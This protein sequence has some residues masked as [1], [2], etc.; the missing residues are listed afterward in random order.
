[1]AEN[2]EKLKSLLMKV[3]EESEKAGLKLIQ[4]TNLIASSS[5][6][7]WQ[8]DGETTERVTDFT[9][10][11]SK[12]TSDSDCSHK[13]KKCL[14]L[15]RKAMTNPDIYD[16]P[17]KKQRYHLANKGPSSQSYGFSNSHVWIWE[18][19]HKEGC[20]LNNWCFQIVVLKKTLE[21]PFN[22]KEIK[23]VNP[24]GDQ[25]WIFI[26]RADAKAAI[27]WPPDAK[28]RLIGKDANVGKDWWWE[29]KGKTENELVGWPHWLSGH[30]FE[31]TQG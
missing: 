21:S 24:K 3:K 8:I 5:I 31:Y 15:G 9:F 20:V 30:E 6:T 16:K 10:L 26:G 1:M 2:E 28:G 19:D 4:K 18:V 17:I 13:I 29:E 25:P 23:P 11:G 14:L 27:L 22:S 7:S 12:I